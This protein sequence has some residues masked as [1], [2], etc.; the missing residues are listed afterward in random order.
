MIGFTEEA[1]S[2]GLIGEESRKPLHGSKSAGLA[3]VLVGACATAGLL[4]R[5]TAS[6][7]SAPM[8]ALTTLEEAEA[9]TTKPFG[10]CAGMNFSGTAADRAAHNFSMVA[11]PFACC[12]LGTSCISF[13][14]V[15]D[16]P[17]LHRPIPPRAPTALHHHPPH[18][19]RASDGPCS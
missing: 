16:A 2:Y 9:C 13:G 3:L 14:P 15:Y 6:S 7:A 18:P 19:G 5:T 8:I 1:D 11:E 4:A 12:P 10:Q 17:T